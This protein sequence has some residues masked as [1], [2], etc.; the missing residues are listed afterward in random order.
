MNTLLKIDHQLVTEVLTGLQDEELVSLNEKLY[1]S[2]KCDPDAQLIELILDDG[3]VR[4]C[5]YADF[6]RLCETILEKE[7]FVLGALNLDV[8]DL[9]LTAAYHLLYR[10]DK[11]VKNYAREKEEQTLKV[12]RG[13][14]GRGREQVPHQDA[15]AV[16]APADM[17]SGG[18]LPDTDV[19]DRYEV[20][21]NF[22]TNRKK[23]GDNK[24]L[25][26]GDR[27][28]AV[29]YGKAVIHI[30]ESHES[31]QV[32]K[33]S[34]W[35]LQFSENP[36]K[37]ITLKTLQHEEEGEFFSDIKGQAAGVHQAMIFVHGFNVAFRAGMY[38]AAQLKFD[39]GFAGPMILFSWP[40]KG[41]VIRYTHDITNAEY[42]SGKLSKAIERISALGIKEIFLIGHSMGTRCLTMALKD[43][44]ARKAGL[45]ILESLV[46]AAPD[47][48]KKHFEDNIVESILPLIKSGVIYISNTDKALS[49]SKLING[50]GRLGDVD[51][52]VP[53]FNIIDTV[54]ATDK[55]GDFLQHS[56]I[57][58]DNR[59]IDDLYHFLFNKMPPGKRRL[60][61]VRNQENKVFWK[62]A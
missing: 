31:G 32:E 5:S 27:D 45:P 15:A 59:V 34:I 10:M 18:G 48:D 11:S 12:S 62:F 46:L 61:D 55:G 24:E 21:V 19:Q 25:F 49:A 28:E 2:L 16:V 53:V 26:S 17:D 6:I 13:L 50:Y 8:T 39:L 37:H 3:T 1:F 56:Y 9:E 41:S 33:P 47:I 42:A 58:E 60:R 40:S 14:S 4:I 35:K 38:K 23:A 20:V 51:G 36:D 7:S 52:D 44:A 57:T 43:L 29:H 22:I 30:P 54:D